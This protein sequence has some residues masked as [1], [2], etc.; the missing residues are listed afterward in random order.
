M[1][2]ALIIEDEPLVAMLIEEALEMAGATTVDIA[3]TEA[4]AIQLAVKHRPAVITSD[5]RLVEGSGP[6]AV[7]QIKERLGD[8][9]V[10]FITGSPQECEPCDAGPVLMKP[11]T[12]G[13]I[14]K[15]FARALS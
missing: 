8:I 11:V 14:Q 12:I 6:E 3:E 2:H 4:Q 5:V 1:C 7:Q 13:A 10:I 15:A 9:P